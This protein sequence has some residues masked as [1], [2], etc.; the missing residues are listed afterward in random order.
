M[1][2]TAHA[3][4]VPWERAR[5]LVAG[6]GVS[7]RAAVAALRPRAASVVTV[8]RAAPDA[9][10]Q[11]AARVDLSTIDLVVAS[12]GWAPSS[13]LLVA[14]R[15]AGVTVWSEVE[16]AWQLR[17]PRADG[18]CAPWLAVTGTNGKTTTV[19]MLTSILSAAGCAPQRWGTSAPRS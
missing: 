5:V 1:S 17:T 4:P 19:E 11:D 8:D 18:S 2:D 9:D 10:V 16:L 14:A 12:P 6:L 13:D 3:L 7:G 15:E